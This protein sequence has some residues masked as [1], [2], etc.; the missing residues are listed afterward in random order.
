MIVAAKQQVVGV[1]AQVAFAAP[2]VL[3]SIVL[4]REAS[5]TLIADLALAVGI[6]NLIFTVLS[7][8]LRSYLGL[9]GFKDFEENVFIANRAY[10]SIAGIAI[11]TICLILVGTP[12]AIAATAILIKFAD[13]VA[14][15]R[16]SLIL[17]R[18]QLSLALRNYLL[19]SLV[20]LALFAV[21]MSVALN[22]LQTPSEALVV[23]SVVQSLFAVV[24]SSKST[25]VALRETVS[26]SIYRLARASSPLSIAAVSC[27]LLTVLPRAAIDSVYQPAER[28]YAGIAFIVGTFFGMAFN[29]L[30]IR[31]S[32]GFQKHGKRKAI[33]RFAVEGGV[34]SLALGIA[35]LTTKDLV[36]AIYGIEDSAFDAT[37]IPIGVTLIV[38]FFVMSS[39]N[40]LK[41]VEKSIHEAGVYASS[42][43]V[44]WVAVVISTN[45]PL[46]LIAGSLF[47]LSAVAVLV[48]QTH[49]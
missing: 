36:A 48:R 19:W 16:F 38:F 13:S 45:M 5:V 32:V 22:Y 35:L 31:T 21:S 15:I 3:V 10:S 12:I 9:W 20:R 46:A 27:G 30:W 2:I 49:A 18:R 33:Q 17:A 8:G 14:D 47:M 1:T 4:S 26:G 29:T 41:M 44:F 28:G 11:S 37:Y 6:V 23:G 34:I 7:F 25:W 42:A 39:A 24:L 40:L 43:A